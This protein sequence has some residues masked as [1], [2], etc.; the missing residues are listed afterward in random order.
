MVSAFDQFAVG[1]LQLLDDDLSGVGVEHSD[2]G[3]RMTSHPPFCGERRRMRR[4][5]SSCRSCCPSPPSFIDA[6]LREGVVDVDI[7]IIGR[8]PG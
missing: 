5:P 1:G 2:G 6:D 7:R 8:V 3:D 4:P